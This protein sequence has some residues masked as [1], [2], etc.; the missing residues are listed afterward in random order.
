MRQVVLAAVAVV[1]M[2]V[3]ALLAQQIQAA[4]AVGQH[5]LAAQVVRE[6]LLFAI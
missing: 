6:L 5:L 3:M 1:T 2:E 4:V